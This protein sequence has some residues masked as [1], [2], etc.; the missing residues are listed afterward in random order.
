MKIGIASGHS[1]N[2]GIPQRL[3]GWERCAEAETVLAQ[4]LTAA[5][6]SVVQPAAELY[7]LENNLA[8]Q[9]KIQLFNDPEIDVAV[10][11]HLNAAGG[12]YSTAIYWDNEGVESSA[13]K[14][15]AADL[16]TQ[17]R[18]GLPWRTIGAQPQSYFQRSL[19]FLNDTRMPAVIVEPAFKDNDE[20]RAWAASQAGPVEYA[21]LVFAGIQRY[22][23][24]VEENDVGKEAA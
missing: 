12:D 15:L 24:R 21:A 4:L 9:A 19:A 13:G 14:I 2:T 23:M 7:G 11:L 22:A 8:L 5:G 3:V 16:C 20:Q 10:E 18:S 6:H 1:R 17:F